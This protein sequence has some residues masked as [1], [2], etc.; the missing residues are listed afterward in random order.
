MQ[1]LKHHNVIRTCRLEAEG[2]LSGAGLLHGGAGGAGVDTRE[3]AAG[4]QR[5]HGLTY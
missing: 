1:F 4:Q 2:L 5:R 3:V